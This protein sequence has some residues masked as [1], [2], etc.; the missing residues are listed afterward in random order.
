GFEKESVV[1]QE[2]PSAQKTLA[3]KSEDKKLNP[4][5]SLNPDFT[6]AA[7]K[8]T[9]AV[10]HIMAVKNVNTR[11]NREMPDIFR[12][13]FG[14]S[15]SREF[16]SL[17]G[18][19]K[20]QGSGSGVIV[21]KD[22]YIVT[23]NHVVEDAAE[24]QVVLSDKR[25]YEAEI[26][27]TAPST[28]LAVIKIKEKDLPTIVL[29]NSEKVQIGEWV[30]AV[31]NPFNLESTV[32]AG[33]V[34]AKGRSLNILRN[35]SRTPIEAFI[36]TD[37]AVNPG[38]S[39]GALINV[40]GEL[41]GI[42]TA[43][44]TPTGTYAGYSFA[45][46][47]NIVKKVMKDLIDFGSIQR[48]YLGIVI[49]EVDGA[50]AKDKGLDVNQGVYIENLEAGGAAEAA[51]LKPGDVIIGLEG[52][53]IRSTPELLGQIA[54]RSPGDKIEVTIRRNKKDITIPVTLKTRDGSAQTLT[55]TEGKIQ[56]S[57]GAEFADLS[58]QEKIDLGI[59]GG[60]KVVNVFGGK[61]RQINIKKDF[62]ITHLSEEPVRV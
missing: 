6:R 21:S 11:Y 10:V 62:V 1:F 41:I 44:A 25:T 58:Q 22:G 16:R 45:V 54:E 3:F 33:I 60:V 32:T 40:K 12:E 59:R 17:R 15:Y 53:K 24:L 46:P 55:K 14:D 30:L 39:G 26:V 7:A 13:F 31:G 61:F 19:Q 56:K 36:Q 57:L 50:L 4:A 49:Q 8:S 52:G 27:G 2:S 38:N 35:K 37:A 28:D 5:Q 51:G 34:S 29:G 20:T 9:E 48:G 23:N 42:N 18:P 47:V 43:I